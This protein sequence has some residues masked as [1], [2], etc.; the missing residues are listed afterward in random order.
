MLAEGM[1]SKEERWKGGAYHEVQQLLSEFTYALHPEEPYF[2]E[3]D[4]AQE[5]PKRSQSLPDDRSLI[6]GSTHFR[7]RTV[8]GVDLGILFS[9]RGFE[10]VQSHLTIHG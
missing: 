7:I 9:A 8:E 5:G 2:L 1:Q 10:V 6:E 3:R 4:P